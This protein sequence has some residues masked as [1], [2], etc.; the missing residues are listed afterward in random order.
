MPTLHEPPAQSV[1]TTA[2]L[3]ALTALK[4]GNFSVRLPLDWTGVAGKVADTFND[5]VELNERMA[6]E[7]ERISR[8]VGK[9]GKIN[10]RA[11]M[12][13]P[14]RAPTTIIIRIEKN[15]EGDCTSPET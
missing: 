9:E 10:Q 13:R 15:P 3:T 12:P 5:V 1:D 8:V 6:Y 11:S 14:R 2:L 7:L 4:K